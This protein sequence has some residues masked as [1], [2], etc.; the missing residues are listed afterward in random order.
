MDKWLELDDMSHPNEQK[1]DEIIDI[2]SVKS[3]TLVMSRGKTLHNE[4]D[5]CHITS[6]MG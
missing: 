2:V 5:G 1:V 6:L 3:H 4:R